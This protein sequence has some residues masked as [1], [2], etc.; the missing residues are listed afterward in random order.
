MILSKINVDSP[1]EEIEIA[2]NRDLRRVCITARYPA[3]TWRIFDIS[4]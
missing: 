3:G 4:F 1:G 2:G